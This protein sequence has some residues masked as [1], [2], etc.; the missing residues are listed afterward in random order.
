MNSQMTVNGKD[1]E[2]RYS[3]RHCWSVRSAAR[4]PEPDRHPCRLRHRQCGACVVHVDGERGEELHD[5]GGAG[6][7]ARRSRRSRAWRAPSGRRCIRCRQAFHHNHGLQCGFCTPG[8][9]MS[10][11]DAVQTRHPNAHRRRG[12]RTGSKAISAAAPA[13]RTSSRRC[14][15][16]PP[17]CSARKGGMSHGMFDTGIGASIAP[18]GG[19]PRSSPARGNYVADIKRA[20]HG[21]R[22]VP[23]LAARARG[24]QAASTQGGRARCRASRRSTPATDLAADKRRR[25]A[26]R[27]GHQRRRRPADEGAAASG[28]GA[29]QGALRRRPGGVRDRRHAGAGARRGGRDRGRLRGAAG[30]RRR[31]RRRTSGRAAVF[32]D[33]ARQHLLRLGVRRQGR[34]ASGVQEGR[35]CR[36]ARAS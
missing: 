28:A 29:G 1:V 24:D 21:D 34:R 9:V 15:P 35:A 3:R 30:R 22:R 18:Q 17:P 16:A 10:A 6:S 36:Q 14:W 26:L 27:L 8:M 11:V 32:D 19:P 20:G 4:E 25:A 7:T 33:V 31:A 2:G 13:I 12:P 5:A 23:A